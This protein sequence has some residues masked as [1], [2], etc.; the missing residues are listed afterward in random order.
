[1]MIQIINQ[2]ELYELDQ[3]HLNKFESDISKA[4]TFLDVIEVI[5]QMVDVL[6][7]H[8]NGLTKYILVIKE[9]CMNAVI[10][11]RHKTIKT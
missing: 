11:I 4:V 3:Q 6:M 10:M 5:K 2:F 7:G 1:M 8:V 9:I